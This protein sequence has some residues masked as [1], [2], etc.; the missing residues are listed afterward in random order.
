MRE[1]R[2]DWRD[3]FN[4]FAIALDPRKMF[5]ALAGMI[6]TFALISV[7]FWLWD[8]GFNLGLGVF[9]KNFSVVTMPAFFGTLSDKLFATQHLYVALAGIISFYAGII[10]IFIFAWSFFGGAITRIAAVEIAK[11]ERIELSNAIHFGKRRYSSFF[12]SK[13]TCILLFLFFFLCIFGACLLA[14]IPTLGPFL[15]ILLVIFLPLAMITSFLLTMLGLGATFGHV[16]FFPAVAAEDT[17]A[18]DAISRGFSYLFAEPWKF[19]WYQIVSG[20]YGF[21]TFMFV[22]VFSWMLMLIML[23]AARFGMGSRSFSPMIKNIYAFFSEFFNGMQANPNPQMNTVEMISTVIFAAW[24]LLFAGF[25]FSFALSYFFSG[26][27]MIYFL[28]RKK[29]DSIDMTEVYEEKESEE[30]LKEETPP[31]VPAEQPKA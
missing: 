27:T 8:K 29:V 1:L 11:D 6:M 17:D 20:V 23:F 4:N 26:Q 12:W 19:I 10:F 7:W 14:R 25:V 18:F 13:L 21:I 22:L 24:I 15:K 31:A 9:T 16:L 3:L 30:E 2:G 5:L 28:L